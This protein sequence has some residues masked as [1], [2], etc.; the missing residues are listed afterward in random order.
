MSEIETKIETPQ[1]VLIRHP[2]TK[3]E[4]WRPCGQGWAHVTAKLGDVCTLGNGCT[5]EKSPFTFKALATPQIMQ[6][7]V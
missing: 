2:G 1:W 5:L 6:A 4:D 7:P 3:V